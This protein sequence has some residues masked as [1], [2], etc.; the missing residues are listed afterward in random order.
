[1]VRVSSQRLDLLLAVLLAGLAG[2]YRSLLVTGD[3]A[4]VKT[5]HTGVGKVRLVALDLV[6]DL[7]AALAKLLHVIRDDGS[8]SGGIHFGDI[9]IG[10]DRLIDCNL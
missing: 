4:H 2:V 8:V 6:G 10:I 9:D 5:V 1:M 7:F 3:D